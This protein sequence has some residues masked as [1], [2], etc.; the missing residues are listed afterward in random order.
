[1]RKIDP[2]WWKRKVEKLRL[3]DGSQRR[4]QKD[5]PTG[6]GRTI[7]RLFMTGTDELK[8]VSAAS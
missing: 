6:G 7:L 5:E 4:L 8:D 2:S 3:E 1:M